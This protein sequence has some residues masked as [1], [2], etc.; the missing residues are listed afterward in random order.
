M[1]KKFTQIPNVIQEDVISGKLI[2]NDLV[3]YSYLVSK[4]SHG[5]PIFF[6]ITEWEKI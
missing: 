6:S 2:G 3:V 5:K 4:A 1:M